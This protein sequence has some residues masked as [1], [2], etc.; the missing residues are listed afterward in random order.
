MF[1]KLLIPED[2]ANHFI[3]G[4]LIYT[5]LSLIHQPLTGL[6]VCILAGALKEVYDYP[7]HDYKDFIV[8]VLGGVT[9]YICTY[10]LV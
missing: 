6:I 9:G 2:K 8:T 3:Y 10:Y 4:I 1:K 7:K 5:T